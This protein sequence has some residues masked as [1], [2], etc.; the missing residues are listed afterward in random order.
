[1]DQIS[2]DQNTENRVFGQQ[3]CSLAE[4]Q[5]LGKI[6]MLLLAYQ[7]KQYCRLA[8]INKPCGH[9]VEVG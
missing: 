7:P 1:M 4:I 3:H 2:Q 5:E 6:K 8:K 9:S